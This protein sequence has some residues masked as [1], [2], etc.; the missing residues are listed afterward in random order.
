MGMGFPILSEMAMS[1]MFQSSSDIAEHKFYVPK[2]WC[3]CRPPIFSGWNQAI[4]SFRAATDLYPYTHMYINMD[5]GSIV[6]I[7]LK[8]QVH[9]Q[10]QTVL[11]WDGFLCHRLDGH[12]YECGC[13]RT[14]ID[15]SSNKTDIMKTM[16]KYYWQILTIV[17]IDNSSN[18]NHNCCENPW[19]G[20]NRWLDC[21][22]MLKCWSDDGLY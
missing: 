1:Q 17:Q 22:S 11:F 2:F 5:F 15:H 14:N 18:I 4:G 20:W 21:W 16:V 6:N 3:A 8:C 13:L 10:Q 12:P 19:C 9:I 7:H